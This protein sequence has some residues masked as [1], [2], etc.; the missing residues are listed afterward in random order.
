MDRLEKENRELCK[1]VTTLRDRFEKLT[2]MMETLVATHKHPPPPHQTPLPRTVV[3]EIVSTPISVA[4]VS[5][6]QHYMSPSFPWGMPHHFVPKGYQPIV[7]VPMA[8]VVMFVLPLVVHVAPY[9]EEPIF[10]D[11]QS[12]IVGVSERMDKFQDQFKAM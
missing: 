2:A 1:A 5:F 7:E 12:E 3:S 8:Q 9:V 6:L 11:N 10:H 4:P